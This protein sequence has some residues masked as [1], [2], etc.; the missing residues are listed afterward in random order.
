[1]INGYDL[2]AVIAICI[3][4]YNCVEII[5]NYKETRN[6]KTLKEE[7]KSCL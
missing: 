5:C 4:V 6:N 1:M 7:N 3:C 2:A